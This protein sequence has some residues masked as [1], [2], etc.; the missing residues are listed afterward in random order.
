MANYIN[1]GISKKSATPENALVSNLFLAF[2]SFPLFNLPDFPFL[3]W[4]LE[5]DERI[6]ESPIIP[7]PLLE[8]EILHFLQERRERDSKEGLHLGLNFSRAIDVAYYF[9]TREQQEVLLELL[10]AQQINLT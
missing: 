5:L 2:L 7:F 3:I 6:E 1:F 9:L 10:Q 8:D 4:S